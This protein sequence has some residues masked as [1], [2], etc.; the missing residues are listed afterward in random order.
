MQNLVTF[1]FVYNCILSCTLYI[2]SLFIVPLEQ[3][4]PVHPSLQ[5]HTLGLVHL[6]LVQPF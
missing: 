6:P 2:N 3:V 5:L 4:S 1:Y